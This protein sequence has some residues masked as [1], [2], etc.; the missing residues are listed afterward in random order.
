MIMQKPKMAIRI[1]PRRTIVINT[2][3]KRVV[4]YDPGL[5]GWVT[6]VVLV[7]KDDVI[8]SSKVLPLYYKMNMNNMKY[9]FTDF[10]AS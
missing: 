10:T 6:E 1:T 4:L 9:E 5:V 7:D 8:V 2:A 3:T